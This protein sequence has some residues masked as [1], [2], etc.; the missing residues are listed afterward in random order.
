MRGGGG[1]ADDYV[2]MR[3]GIESISLYLLQ[4]QAGWYAC[5]VGIISQKN[6]QYDT[7]QHGHGSLFFVTVRWEINRSQKNIKKLKKNIGQMLHYRAKEIVLLKL[8][9]TKIRFQNVNR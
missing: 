7:I 1:V 6:S 2:L 4:L 3:D 5:D 8:Y 9:M